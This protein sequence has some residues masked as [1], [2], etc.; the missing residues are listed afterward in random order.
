MPS[1]AAASLQVNDPKTPVKPTIINKRAFP[2][3]PEKPGQPAKRLKTAGEKPSTDGDVFVAYVAN[4]QSKFPERYQVPPRKSVGA[5]R[6]LPFQ[7]EK[8][9]RKQTLSR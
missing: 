7:P 4:A 5:S 9:T 8:D 1:P 6:T 2:D 3:S